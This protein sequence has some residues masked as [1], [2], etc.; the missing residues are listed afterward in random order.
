MATPKR[1]PMSEWLD[2]MLEEVERK[3][4]EAADAEAEAARR[5]SVKDGE[6]DDAESVEVA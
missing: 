1:L 5:A 2:L 4:N 6:A 3:K